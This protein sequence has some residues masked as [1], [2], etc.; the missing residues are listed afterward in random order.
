[1]SAMTDPSR[2]LIDLRVI[3]RELGSHYDPVEKDEYSGQCP[4]CEEM[5]SQSEDE[6]SCGNP[7]VWRGSKMWR[8]LYG[9]PDRALARLMIVVPEDKIGKRLV[10]RA[11]L[12]GFANKTEGKRWERAVK[13][14]GEG[15][16]IGIIDHAAKTSAGRGMISFVLNMTDKR[17]RERPRVKTKKA[18]ASAHEAV[19]DMPPRERYQQER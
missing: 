6:C 15:D 10:A 14:I 13:N 7:I 4:V 9:D 18:D 8:S 5:V 2:H 12:Q 17:I 19:P 3:R 11:G 16:L 1:M